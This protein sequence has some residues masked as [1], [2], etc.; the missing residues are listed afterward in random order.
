MW[1]DPADDEAMIVFADA[2]LR[3]ES[4]ARI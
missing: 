4:A 2:M 3:F 1:S